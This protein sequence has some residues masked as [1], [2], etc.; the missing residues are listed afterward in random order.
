[1]EVSI[2]YGSI[3]ARFGGV[4]SYCHHGDGASIQPDNPLGITLLEIT[5]S[6]PGTGY[7][8]LNPTGQLRTDLGVDVRILSTVPI[9]TVI[10]VTHSLVCLFTRATRPP[11]WQAARHSYIDEALPIVVVPY[12]PL[13]TS[14]ASTRIRPPAIGHPSNT[15]VSQL[16]AIPLVFDTATINALPSV[17]DID[18]LPVAWGSWNDTRPNIDTYLAAFAGFHGE[19][20]SGW[21]T[22]GYVP[23]LQTL[24]GGYGGAF[25]AWV[26]HALLMMVSTDNATK[27]RQ[28]AQRMVQWGVD[29]VGSYAHGRT[30]Y[31]DGGHMQG[32]KALIVLSG[33][34]LEKPWKDATSFF[35]T[36]RFNEDIQFFTRSSPPAWIWGWPYGYL[37]K[38]GLTGSYRV[39]IDEPI[40]T[41]NERVGYYLSQYFQQEVCGTQLG[42]S[43]AMQILGLTNEMGLGHRGMMEQWVEGPSPANLN[44]M[45][46]YDVRLASVAWGQSSGSNTGTH[47]FGRGAWDVYSDYDPPA[48]AA[49]TYNHSAHPSTRYTATVGGQPLPLWGRTTDTQFSTP[50]WSSGQMVSQSG[51]TIATESNA[52]IEVSLISGSITSATVYTRHPSLGKTIPSTVSAGKLSFTLPPDSIAWCEING[53]RGQPLVIHSKPPITQ[54]SGPTVDLYNGT[55]T[56]AVAGRTLVF[57]AGTHTIGQSFEVPAGAKVWLHGE[58]WVIGSFELLGSTGAD[59]IAGHG[60]LSGEWGAALRTYIRSLPFETAVTYSLIHGPFGVLEDKTVSGIT[61]L[62]PPFYATYYGANVY[63]RV[64][65]VGPWWGNANAFFI[66]QRWPERTGSATKCCAFVHDDV[67]DMGEYLGSNEFRGNVIGSIASASFIVSYWPNL[68]TSG[69][70]HQ[71]MGNTVVCLNYAT[72]TAGDIVLAWCDGSDEAEVVDGILI[73]GCDFVGSAINGRPFGIQNRQYPIEWGPLQELRKGQLINFVF[74]NITFEVVPTFKSKIE[75][76]DANNHPRNIVFENVWYGGTRLTP[77]NFLDFFEIDEFAENITVDGQR[78]DTLLRATLAGSSTAS[79]TVSGRLGLRGVAAG[80][81]SMQG[82]MSFRGALGALVAGQSSLQASL[83]VLTPIGLAAA[84]AGS[85]SMSA[86][87]GG[88]FAMSAA[89]YG[90]SSMQANIGGGAQGLSATFAGTSSFYAVLGIIYDKAN[91]P[92]TSPM[93]QRIFNALLALT[94][95]GPYHEAKVDAKT[96]QMT[97]YPSK[98]VKPVS[99]DVVEVEK[100]MAPASRYRRAFNVAEIESWIFEVKIQFS[101]G[102]RVSCEV[103]ENDVSDAGI[104]IPEAKNVPNQ[105]TLLAR[106]VKARYDEPPAQNPSLGSVVFFTFEV[107]PST[108]RK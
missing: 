77:A 37:G 12:G 15:L 54:P 40:N 4:A 41:W 30:D 73:D 67:F 65:I 95:N 36:D 45:V 68:D 53:V 59:P 94:T 50:Y 76:L 35:G 72:A 55:Q 74:R 63:E 81:S 96:G 48:P 20:W 93:K 107:V 46:A 11:G 51:A 88:L 104:T 17:I 43:V 64:T 14:Q 102:L 16:R 18:A 25:S 2:T 38:S 7:Q 42:V 13:N 86:L 66:A 23:F 101:S 33:H 71:A 82:S 21:A 60:V 19:L 34:L 26:S 90:S 47:G 62:D 75:G 99:V 106:L 27:R 78:V 98:T 39:N 84:S 105:R 32:R 58:A 8:V 70:A 10:Q 3:T 56:T 29:Y 22:E 87:L 49:V 52:A 91:A 61:L 100:I 69:D 103:F 1:M 89:S 5:Y 44:A 79:A 9:G 31:V 24:G 97:V 83:S 57:P 85:S 28:L 80:T 108:L 6:L 92:D